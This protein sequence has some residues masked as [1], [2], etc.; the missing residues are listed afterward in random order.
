MKKIVLILLIVIGC[1]A[2]Q[3]AQKNT[4]SD[5]YD[6][7]PEKI[8]TVV[9]S[10]WSYKILKDNETGCE[11]LMVYSQGPNGGVYAT[12]LVD[13]EGKPKINKNFSK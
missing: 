1:I 10:G 3:P 7:C 2:C 9:E 5:S 6:Q 8:M 11:Y 4:T 12:L 13:S